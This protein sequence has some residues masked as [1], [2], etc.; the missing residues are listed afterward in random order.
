MPD[1]LS[2]SLPP[3]NVTIV[4]AFN[5]AIFQPAWIQRFVPEVAGEIETLMPFGGGPL[6]YHAGELDWSVSV[7]RLVIYGPAVRIGRFAAQVLRELPH[8]PL[9]AVGV[10]FLRRERLDRAQCGPWSMRESE[11]VAALLD[12]VPSDFSIARVA[13][14]SDGVRLTV[15][16]VWPSS[17]PEAV[18]DFNYHRD[19]ESPPGETRAKELAAHAERA[20]EFE[21]D[22]AR[23][24]AALRRG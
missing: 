2:R 22:M 6:L 11:E 1:E 24:T 9:R 8:T 16:I 3:Q 7:E 23:I 12:G 20:C 17:E 13:R 15:K 18:A 14:R 5:P 21:A 4:G 10:N 19:A